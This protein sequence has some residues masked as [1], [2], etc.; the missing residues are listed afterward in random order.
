MAQEE[1]PKNDTIEE[2][3]VISFQ[4]VLTP[5]KQEKPLLA[6][7]SLEQLAE[8]KQTGDYAQL[9]KH[10]RSGALEILPK[11]TLYEL[12]LKHQEH[13]VLIETLRSALEAFLPLAQNHEALSKYFDADSKLKVNIGKIMEVNGKVTEISS[14]EQGAPVVLFG[15]GEA[16]GGVLCTFEMG[17]KAKIASVK[18]GDEIKVKGICSGMIMEVVLNRCTLVH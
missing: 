18:V 15:T 16:F 5:A 7:V 11:E 3:P 9:E 8:W 13:A 14:D 17:E 10:I 4:S 2:I 12:V 1:Q 6:T